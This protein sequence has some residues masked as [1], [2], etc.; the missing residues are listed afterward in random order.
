MGPS[1]RCS[2][3]PEALPWSNGSERSDIMKSLSRFPSRAR[4]SGIALIFGAWLTFAAPPNSRTPGRF[5]DVTEKLGIH[6]GQQASPTSKKYLL[7]TMGSGV[8]LFDYDNDG[9]LDIFFANGARLDDPTPKGS[10]PQKD[11][12]KYWN[13]LYHQKSDG[14]FEDVTERAGLAGL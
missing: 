8:A 10:I 3:R 1:L 13:R 6:F 5:V 7:E 2:E 12:P 11:S 9:R 14:T 4:L